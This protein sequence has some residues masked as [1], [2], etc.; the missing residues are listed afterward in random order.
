MRL[1]PI[2]RKRKQRH[3]TPHFED[4]DKTGVSLVFICGKIS[5]VR[6]DSSPLVCDSL[7]EPYDQA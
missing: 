1:V 5:A 2:L 4:V 3:N 6:F 7:P